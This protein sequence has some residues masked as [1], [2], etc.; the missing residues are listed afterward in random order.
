MK[1]GTI[2]KTLIAFGVI[3]LLYALNMSV[4]MPESDVVNLHM[5]SERQNMFMI[6]GLLFIGGIILFAVTKLKQTDEEDVIERSQQVENEEKIKRAKSQ[7]GL[8]FIALWRWSNINIG[9]KII[10]ATACIAVFTLLMDWFFWQDDFAYILKRMGREK[11]E[12]ESLLG[13]SKVYILVFLPWIYPVLVVIRNKSINRMGSLICSISFLIL[14]IS[15]AIRL[16]T[17]IDDGGGQFVPTYGFWLF[18]LSSVGLMVGIIKYIPNKAV[19]LDDEKY[20]A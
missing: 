2:G 3:F 11:T 15:F 13:L 8:K 5:I 9:G 10:I 1:I 4:S 18:T 7:L 19:N 12:G 14:T 6:G 20:K 16:C 17:R